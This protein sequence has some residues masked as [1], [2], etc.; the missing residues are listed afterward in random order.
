MQNNMFNFL[1][2]F[3]I[4]QT[5]YKLWLL[6]LGNHTVL[7]I[8]ALIAIGSATRVMEAGLACPDWPLCYGTF[9]PMT[10]MNLRV[11]SRMVS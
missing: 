1:N 10:H 3:E 8:I 6:K 5:K 4:N 2:Q 9:L 7:A 11:F